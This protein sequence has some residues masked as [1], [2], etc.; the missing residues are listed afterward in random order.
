M[1]SGNRRRPLVL[2]LFSLTLTSES[3]YAHSF[4]RRPFPLWLI[5]C[6]PPVGTPKGRSRCRVSGI[7]TS[8]YQ[9]DS[10][11]SGRPYSNLSG[12][13]FLFHPLSALGFLI[14]QMVGKIPYLSAG[15]AWGL[16]EKHDG[17]CA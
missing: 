6:A 9:V 15:N 4:I 16:N 2:P 14:A 1:V 10:L 5:F 7:S 13:F 3:R 8:K 11:P 12:P 17:M